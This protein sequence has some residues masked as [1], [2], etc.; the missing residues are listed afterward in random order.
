MVGLLPSSPSIRSTYKLPVDPHGHHVGSYAAHGPEG[1]SGLDPAS[2]DGPDPEKIEKFHTA[3][4]HDHMDSTFQT[5]ETAM[6]QLIGV[7]ILE[8][9]VI[10]HRH[11]SS[12]TYH[13][14]PT[15]LTEPAPSV[16]IGLTLAVDEKFKVLFVVVIFHR[17][18]YLSMR[19]YPLART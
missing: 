12:I 6:A 5:D 8:F 11:I 18:Y 1:E 10:L 19:I 13:H 16:L 3:H 9:G 14:Y 7:A 15:Q 4:A 2:G 17:M